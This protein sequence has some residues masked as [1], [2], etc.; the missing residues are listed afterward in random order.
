MPTVYYLESG[1]W[2]MEISIAWYRIGLVCR[3]RSNADYRIYGYVGHAQVVGV[4]IHRRKGS[5]SV[6]ATHIGLQ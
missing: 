3:C 2:F 5:V 6:Q 4:K 1:K